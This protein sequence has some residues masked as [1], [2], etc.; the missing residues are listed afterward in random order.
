LGKAFENLLG[1]YNEETKETARKAYGS[2]YTPR[3]IVNYMVDTSLKEYFKEKLTTRS[4]SGDRRGLLSADHIDNIGKIDKLFSYTDEGHDFEKNE[5]AALIEAINNAKI[6]DP[7]CGSGAFP[8]GILQRLVF[9]LTKLD[10]DNTLWKDAQRKKAVAETEE[11]FRIGNKE[12]LNERLKEISDIFESNSNDYGRKLFLIENCIYGVDIQPIAI[13]ISKLRFFIS[14]IVDQSAS[15]GKGDNYSIR[16]LPNLETKFV[17]AN[18]LLGV[19]K[20]PNAQGVFAD[21]RIAQKQTELLLI[22]HNHFG[23]TKV[24]EKRDLRNQ[25]RALSKELAEILKNDGFCNSEDAEQMAAWNPYDPSAPAPFFDPDWMFGI[26]DGFDVVIGNPPYVFARNSKS[27]GLSNTQKSFYYANYELA[28][29]QINL[30]PLFIEASTKILKKHGTI[31][32]ITPNNWLT[33]NTNKKLRRFVLG[34]SSVAIL[35]FYAR[36]FESADVDAAIVLFQNSPGDTTNEKIRLLEWTTELTLIDDVSKKYFFSDEESIINIDSFKSGSPAS[37]L[38][39]IEE[40][41]VPLSAYAKIKC[42]LGAYGHGDGIP[43]QTHEM[44]QNRIY[45]SKTK[46]GQDW[47]K[48]I[49]GE[50][51]KRFFLSWNRKE[52]LKWGK[53]LR[54]PRSDWGLFSTPR[55]LVRQ[56]PSPLPYCINACFTDEVI[57]NDR[58][59]MNVVYMTTTPQLILAILNSRLISFWFANKFGKLQ[60]GIFPQFKINELAKFPV[61]KN[62]KPYEKTIIALVDKILAAKAKDSQADTSALER[63]IDNLVYRLYNLAYDEVKVIE[64]DFPLSEAEYEGSGEG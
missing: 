51:V 32:L 56:I 23:A 10:Q 27:K 26:K 21:P 50:D 15:G 41:T 18:S 44:I 14:L 20:K 31:C 39:K 60:R 40:N 57:L 46:R 45:H 48:Y 2:F 62:F 42:G 13:Q 7:A 17:A 28:E 52:Y 4:L 59:S 25:D 43:P 58:N 34:K 1:T 11:T 9:V 63:Q 47:F 19:R 49:E 61:P 24:K 53:Q 36:V 12:N 30:Y 3:E 29:Y 38:L 5:V 54:E 6:L 8:M 35:N 64:P 55:I 33:L 22:R 37:F 16:P